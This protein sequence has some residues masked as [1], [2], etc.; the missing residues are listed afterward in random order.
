MGKPSDL[1]STVVLDQGV[2]EADR[3]PDGVPEDGLPFA[4]HQQAQ[5][6]AVGGAPQGLALLLGLAQA[7]AVVLR[8][9]L[10]R[11]LLAAHLLQALPR[12]PAAVG[13]PGG[14][15]FGPHLLVQGQALGLPVGGVWPPDVR[16][17]VP[18]QA[19]P[20]QAVV[21]G[22]FRLGDEALLVGVLDADDEL[23]SP[24][25]GQGEVDHGH[26]GVADVQ[27]AGGGGRQAHPHRSGS[28]ASCVF[29]LRS[30]RSLARCA[31]RPTSS[32]PNVPTPDART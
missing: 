2:L 28:R 1:S 23:P 3:A 8:G 26:E 31:G 19:Q 11:L 16:A 29:H 30:P 5:H 13:L 32:R 9:L 6:R 21:D 17:L 10:A 20:A 15:Q 27:V 12:A 25:A 7:Q 4:W 18:L 24:L 14:Q 22:L